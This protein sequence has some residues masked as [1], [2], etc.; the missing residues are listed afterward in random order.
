MS[1]FAKEIIPVNLEDEMRQSYLDYAMSVIVGRAL[2]DVR[3]GLKPVH[4]RVLYAMSELGNDWNK[5]YKKSAR[6]VG[7]VIGKYHPHGDTAVYDTMVRMAQPFSLRYMLIDGQGNFGSVDGD[8]AAA[9]RYT[10]VRMSKIAHELLADLD[11]ETVN[12]IPNYDESEVQPDVLPTRLPNLLVNGSSGIAVGMAT[13]IP[14]HNLSEVI[15]ACLAVID[16]PDISVLDLMEHIP[17]PDF[18]TAGIINGASGIYSA[19]TTG[20]GKIYMRARCHFEDIG[21]TSRQAIITTELPYQVNKARLLEKIAELIKEAKLEGISALRDESDKDGM[22]MV[23]ELRRGEMPEVVLNNLYKQTQFQTVFG[24]NMVALLGGRPYCM[25]LKEILDAF[26]DHRRE[27]VTRRTVYLLRKARDRAHILEGLAVALANIN[28]MIELIRASKNREEAKAGLLEKSWD[29]GLVSSLLESA[30]ATRSRPEDLAEQF[31]IHGGKYSLSETQAHAILDLRLH[32]LTGLEQD[33]IVEE[34]KQLLAQIDEYLFILANDTR[35]ME[36][37][38]EELVAIKDEYSDKRRT[39]IVQDH[40]DLSDGDLITVEDMVV[41]MSHEGYVK[42][43]PLG[44]YKAQRR[45]GRGKSA[46]AMKETDYIDKLIVANTHDTVLC[47]SS[48]GKVY[49]LKVYQLPVASR[50]ARGKPFVNLLPLEA[51]EKINA[52]LPISEFTDNKFIF[53]ATSAGTVKKTPLS[54]FEKPR[55]TGK[56]AIDLRDDDRLVGV[57]V[58]DGQQN[59]L[60]FSSTGKAVCF[61]EEDVRS[62]GRA[63]S[64]VRGMRLKDGEKIISL[65]ISTEGTVLNITENGYGKRTRLEEFTCH[66][67]G[68]QGLIAIQTSPRNGAVVGAVLV[69]DNDE[70]MLI[71]DG[72]TLVRTRVDGISVVG[73]NTQG[74]TIIRL[75]KKEKVIGVDR[76]EGLAGDEDDID[77]D[78]VLDGELGVDG[79]IAHDDAADEMEAE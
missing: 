17:G 36:I 47:F 39:E 72:G 27:I 44:D 10:E 71:S 75:D 23:I 74:V 18:P 26:I 16:Q 28:E 54:E 56:I 1:N 70:I 63:A 11:K 21:D 2:P 48:L 76:I 6:I 73:R 35:L 29:A 22:R 51:D 59:V 4:R 38:R 24:I 14:S 64:G 45:G 34:Y 33:K 53:M 15:S 77:V 40:S 46:T 61:N 62:M 49:W 42:A 78:A 20:R 43:Q 31:G 5:P 9:M 7:D 60:L 57:A 58:T 50:A 13:N 12:F 66:K 8:P 67:R 37:I 30:D 25:N 52:L 65:I 69:N 68:G 19:Y 79:S 55:S 3:D 32:R 41:T